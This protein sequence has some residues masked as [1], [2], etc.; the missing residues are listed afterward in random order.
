VGSTGVPVLGSPGLERWHDD[1]EGSGGRALGVGSLGVWR[2]GKEGRGRSGC[3]IPG[4]YAKTE[5]SSY[6]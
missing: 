4:F 3:V 1:S 5:Y 6:A 2:E